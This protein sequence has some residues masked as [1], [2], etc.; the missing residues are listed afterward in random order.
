MNEKLELLAITLAII[1]VLVLTFYGKNKE[2]NNEQCCRTQAKEEIVLTKAKPKV[3]QI[4]PEI[5]VDKKPKPKRK[6]KPRAK[7]K[8]EVEV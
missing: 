6:Y 3:K 8:V 2:N 1:A 7:K 4:Q 5:L